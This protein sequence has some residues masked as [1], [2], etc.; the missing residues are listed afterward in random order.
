MIIHASVK[1]RQKKFFVEKGDVWVISVKSPPEK[2]MANAEIVRE[3]SNLYEDVRILKGMKSTKKLICL[4][5][6]KS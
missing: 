6:R 4:G 5:N 1:T 2:G 3:L